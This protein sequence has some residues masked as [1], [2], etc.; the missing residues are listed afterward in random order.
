MRNDASKFNLDEGLQV[1]KL[2][3]LPENASTNRNIMTSQNLRA[4]DYP[5]HSTGPTASQAV[6]HPVE[7][8]RAEANH[9]S[10]GTHGHTGTGTGETHST[11]RGGVGNIDSS[12]NEHDG[13]SDPSYGT[14][15][16]GAGLTSGTTGTH[17]AHDPVGTT[18]GAHHTGNSHLPSTGLGAVGTGTTSTGTHTGAHTGTHTGATGSHAGTTGSTG[19]DHKVSIGDKIRGTVEKVAGKVTSDPELVAEGQQRK[20]GTHPSQSGA[21]TTAGMTGTTGHHTTGTHGGV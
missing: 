19:T 14:S 16:T 17:H 12:T 1:Y 7:S 5:S 21:G 11:G 20:E 13:V 3:S 10:R 8:A 6:R 4:N 2:A 15:T 18:H 9:L